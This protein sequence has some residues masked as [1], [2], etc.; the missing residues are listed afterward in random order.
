MRSFVVVPDANKPCDCCLVLAWSQVEHRS[1]LLW[2]CVRYA[3]T[4]LAVAERLADQH[5]PSLALY[6]QVVLDQT[7]SS[8]LTD[9][10]LPSILPRKCGILLLHRFEVSIAPHLGH[11][12]GCSI[13][14]QPRL[15]R[16]WQLPSQPPAGFPGHRGPNVSHLQINVFDPLKGL[17]HK[18]I[19]STSY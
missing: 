9:C 4:A 7:H 12:Q 17:K 3:L 15:V 11:W 8:L 16:T 1:Y 19:V 14:R 10:Q 18:L 13:E 6:L 2:I 5:P